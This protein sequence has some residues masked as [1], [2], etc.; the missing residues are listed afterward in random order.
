M[1]TVAARTQPATA[2]TEPR[3]DWADPLLL[4]EP[5]GAEAEQGDGGD[6]RPHRDRQP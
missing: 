2:P 4:E 6:A 5:E 3:F 1:T